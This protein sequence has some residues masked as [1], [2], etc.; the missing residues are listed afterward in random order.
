MT[1][2]E[3]DYVHV[4]VVDVFVADLKAKIEEQET[5]IKYLEN[6]VLV[7]NVMNK[8][9]Q[10]KLERA[11]MDEIQYI[12]KIDELEVEL[13]AALNRGEIYALRFERLHSV[14]KE[15]E[16]VAMSEGSQ[17]IFLIADMATRED[18]F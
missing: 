6:K 1:E 7:L 5:A 10:K 11:R 12:C 3:E 17:N 14:L 15:I 8:T 13:E 4:Q 18:G 9:K 2:T 16:Y